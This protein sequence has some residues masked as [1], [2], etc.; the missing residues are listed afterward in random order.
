MMWVTLSLLAL[1]FGIIIFSEVQPH[2]PKEFDFL[3]NDEPAAQVVADAGLNGGVVA[4][5][6]KWY[7]RAQGHAMEIFK[8]FEQAP[9]ASDGLV[10]FSPVVAFLCDEGTL[11]ARI[12]TSRDT[13]GEDD[14][15]VTVNGAS[16]VWDKAQGQNILAPDARKLLL[17][18]KAA[19]APIA[20]GFQFEGESGPTKIH[21]DPSGTVAAYSAVMAH[22]CD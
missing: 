17:A 13:T 12:D 20:F 7:A 1:I 10:Y 19:K 4:L 6:D 21:I 14:T 9:R 2:I 16:Q 5:D 8:S 15:V 18:M 11:M 3:R 22:R